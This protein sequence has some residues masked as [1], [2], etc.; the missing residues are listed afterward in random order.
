M[1]IVFFTVVLGMTNLIL[2]VIV[3]KALQAHD[4][5]LKRQATDKRK[6]EDKAMDKF[7]DMCEEMDVDEDG[8]LSLQ[9]LRQGFRHVPQ[10]RAMLDIMDI[11]EHELEVL[12][13]IM[14]RDGSGEVSYAEFGEELS[15]VKNASVTTTLS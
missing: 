4:D 9:E 6:E 12:F 13:Y 8:M 1:G 11:D 14:D 15:K 10:F 3:D 2:A 5:D 7:M